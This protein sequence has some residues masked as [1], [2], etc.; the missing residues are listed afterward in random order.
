MLTRQTGTLVAY[1]SGERFEMG[2]FFITS[3]H[4]IYYII[5]WHIQYLLIN[6]YIGARNIL[7]LRADESLYYQDNEWR[8]ERFI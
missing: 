3:C 2:F 1:Y 8:K 7:N 5:Q 6:S 4:N